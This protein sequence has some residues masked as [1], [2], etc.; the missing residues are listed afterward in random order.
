MYNAKRNM[1]HVAP[2][3]LSNGDI[4]IN[5]PS[6]PPWDGGGHFLMLKQLCSETTLTG[7]SWFNISTPQGI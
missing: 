4:I 1:H 7:E 5:L 6:S 2:V 3:L